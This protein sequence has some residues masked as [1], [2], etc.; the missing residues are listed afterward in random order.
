MGDR[1]ELRSEILYG[2]VRDAPRGI[3]AK[4]KRLPKHG[5][6][7][8]RDGVGDERA[9]V[10]GLS[11]KGR[12]RVPGPHLPAVGRDPARQ[13][14]EAREERRY[15]D[16]GG[17][18]RRHQV[19]SRTATTSV[20]RITLSPGASGGVPSVRSAEPITV[21]NTGAATSPP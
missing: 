9:A 6:G 10:G 2:D 18:R 20:G 15:I 13:D 17:K 16:V 3:P 21:E 1:A 11:R 19:S 7:A 8:A 14:R 5:A 12:E 4:G